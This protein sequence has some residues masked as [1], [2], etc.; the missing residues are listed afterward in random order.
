MRRIIGAAAPRTSMGMERP[1]VAGWREGHV[2][3]PFI[4][5]IRDETADIQLAACRGREFCL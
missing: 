1:R 3:V 2:F 4:A 5:A